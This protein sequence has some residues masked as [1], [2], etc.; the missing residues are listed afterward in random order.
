MAAAAGAAIVP[1]AAVAVVPAAA[2]VA[3][4]PA[5]A[6]LLADSP[7]GGIAK[8]AA[9]VDP[10]RLRARAGWSRAPRAGAAPAAIAGGGPRAAAGPDRAVI[11]REAAVVPAAIA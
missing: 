9:P 11:V 6:V 8:T 2:V 4:V 1:A 10:R 7:S 3:V 5:A